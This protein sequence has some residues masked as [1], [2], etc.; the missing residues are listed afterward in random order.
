[1][2]WGRRALTANVPL[3]LGDASNPMSLSAVE[4]KLH[5]LA[6]GILSPDQCRT[7]IAS[8]AALGRGELMPLLACLQSAGLASS[9][10]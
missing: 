8:I 6:R 2:V 5:D 3:P 7:L 4:Q 1:M 9:S 10:Q